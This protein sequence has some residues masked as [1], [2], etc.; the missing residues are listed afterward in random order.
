MSWSSGKDSA[1]ALHEVFRAGSFEVVGLLTTVSEA[2]H[3]VSMHGVR[4]ELLQAQAEALGL[5][6]H[7]VP[8]PSP[9]P[10]AVYEERMA[11]MVSHLKLQGVR[12]IIFGDLFLEDIRHYREEKLAGT[13]VEPVFPL[14]GRPT[15]PLAEE[16]IAAGFRS[17]LVCIDP[18]TLGTHFAGRWFTRELLAEFPHSV[19]P[20]G[21]RG[22]F[23]TFV[24]ACPMFREPIA[25][26]VGQVVQR[27][28]F[29]YADV[30]RRLG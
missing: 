21:E 14:W 20:C 6:L 2:F 17:V 22:E 29:V 23:H 10:N 5:P 9:C 12:H 1:F 15:G 26:D 11:D 24:A 4:E 13:G 25:V 16:M 27:E 7:T 3:R 19:D 30:T 8:I 18:K 28:G